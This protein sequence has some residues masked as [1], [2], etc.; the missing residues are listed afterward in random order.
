VAEIYNGY[1]RIMALPRNQRIQDEEGDVREVQELLGF[2]NPKLAK[3][4]IQRGVDLNAL[5]INVDEA[6]LT[7]GPEVVKKFLCSRF[8][9]RDGRIKSH[10]LAP[11]IKN[12]V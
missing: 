5:S 3:Q 7:F 4:L 8:V 12:G 11:A 6:M 10:K 1:D 9:R 2:D